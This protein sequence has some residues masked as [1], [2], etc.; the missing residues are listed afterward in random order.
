MP[1]DGFTLH[2]LARELR[3]ALVGARVDR[4]VQPERDEVLL[5]MRNHNENFNVLFSASAG[6]ARA[7]ITRVKKNNPLE[8]PMLCM[9]LRK[10]LSGARV[11]DVRQID[12]DRIL[13]IAFEHFDELGE[14]TTKTLVCEFMGKHS[15]LIFLTADGKIIDSARHVTEQISSV[16]QVLPG[17]YYQRPPAHGK[18]PFLAL[19]PAALAARLAEAPKTLHKALS[20]CVSGLSTQTAREIAYRTLGDESA[21]TGSLAPEAVAE[22]VV[23]VMQEMLGEFSPALL[24]APGEDAPI[25]AVP[26]PF[27]S[28]AHLDCRP[29]PSL[30]AALDEFYRARDLAERMQQKSAALHRVLKNNLERSEKKLAIQEEALLN[31]ERAED[32]RIKGELLMANLHLVSK[33][34]KRVSVPNYYD[35]ALTPMEIELDERIS[36]AQNA[37]RYF[38]R[39]QKARSAR[40]FA[41]EQ[42][43]IAQE[44]IR[45]LASQLLALETCTEEAELAEIREELEKLGYVRANHNRRQM[46]KLPP[47]TPLRF[48]APSGAEIFVGKN[49]RQNDE[50]TFSAKPGYVWLHAKDMPGSHVIIARENPDEATIRFAASLAARYSS[51]RESGRVPIDYALKKYVKKPSGAKPGFVTYTNQKT[52][53]AEPLREA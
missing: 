51:G 46:K 50:L 22:A 49:N 25:D 24:Y 9:L 26:I 15:N 52:L 28:R 42:K 18:L 16:R 27:K 2:F 32:Y 48:T 29:M 37:Q 44:E 43:A 40:K 35:E 19:E 53:Y 47:S 14:R 41:L 1:M 39:Y 3:E 34:A 31:C 20:E 36:P 30:S 4:A 5:T 8:P 38:K 11:T 17:L 6:C 7:H 13:E 45:Y 33:G 23:R 12:C 10:H 21:S